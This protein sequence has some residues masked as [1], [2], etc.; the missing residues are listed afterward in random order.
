VALQQGFRATPGVSAAASAAVRVQDLD[1]LAHRGRGRGR[2]TLEEPQEQQAACTRVPPV[3]PERELVAVG[4]QVLRGDAGLMG[5]GEPS[6]QQAGHSMD[7]E[8]HLVRA[9]AATFDLEGLVPVCIGDRWWV[10]PQCVADHDRVWGDVAEQ[11]L[12]EVLGVDLRYDLEPTAAERL[13]LGLHGDHD[14]RLAGRA[15]A[16][17][18]ACWPYPATVRQGDQQGLTRRVDRVH[19]VMVTDLRHFL[20]LPADTP[21]QARR[22]AEH[23]GNI[24]RA[25]TAG[26]AGSVWSSALSCRRRPAHRACLGRMMLL[27]A[28]AGS[29]I[30]WQ[31]SVCDDTGVISNWEDSLFDLRRR[32]L[33]VAAPSKDI[34]IAHVVAEALR[35]LRRLL[36]TECER[37]VFRI[38]AEDADAVLT[39]TDDDLE[40][41]IGAVAAEAN[42]EHNRRRQ[43]RLDAAFDAL[44][45]AACGGR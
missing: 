40:D 22:L 19:A 13:V 33:A 37:L 9:Q 30:R 14:M 44:N 17:L 3:E 35:D 31:C 8:Q 20:D 24:V 29:P 38:R 2:G 7:P 5:A 15:T 10:G 25:A 34:V 12:P 42:H 11:E 1:Q 27:R 4:L 28:E 32:R 36:D 41:L 45:D 39:A 16:S 23:L 43:R 26:D 6:L 18:M 21:G